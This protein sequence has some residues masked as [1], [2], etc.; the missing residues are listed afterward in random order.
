TE[1][2][3]QIDFRPAD[4]LPLDAV[5]HRAQQ[6][7]RLVIEQPDSVGLDPRIHRYGPGGHDELAR[8]VVGRRPGLLRRREEEQRRDDAARP[9]AGTAACTT[10]R[11][12][13]P[14]FC[15]PR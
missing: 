3:R 8:A 7:A 4:D 9:R 1:L 13:A 2:R 14:P 11:M 6:L 15:S 10:V 12:A 5:D